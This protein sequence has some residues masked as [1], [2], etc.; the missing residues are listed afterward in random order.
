MYSQFNI[1]DKKPDLIDKNLLNDIINNRPIDFKSRI[2]NYCIDCIITN[3]KIIFV[4]F[5]ILGC[6]IYRYNQI[7][8]KKL[9]SI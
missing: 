4:F 9:K 6:L 1:N 5:F 3:Y 2:K 7:K 8:K